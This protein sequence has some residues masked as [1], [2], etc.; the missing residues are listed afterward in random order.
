MNWQEILDDIDDEQAILFLGPELIRLDGQSL[1]AHVREQLHRQFPEDI[2][3]HYRRDGIF[4]FRD[5]NAKVKAQKQV[6]RLYRQLP[7][8]EA[9]LQRIAA[10][11][12]HLVIALTPDTFLR[13]AFEQCGLQPHFHYYRSDDTPDSL[14][15]PERGRPLIYNLFGEINHDESLVLD[16]DDVFQLMK[17]CLSTGLPTR[18][19]AQLQRASTFVFLGFD[20]EKWHTQMLLR[21]LSQRPGISKFAI[22]GE[23]PGDDTRDFLLHQ[24]KINFANG[25]E[26]GETFFDSLYRHCRETGKLRP[27]ANLYSDA[28][29]KIMRLAYA[30]KLATALDELRQA[31][32]EQDDLDEI[33]LLGARLHTI[34]EQ[35]K[36]GTLDSRDYWVEWNKIAYNVTR[37]AKKVAP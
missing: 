8:D 37:L 31:L 9:L 14:P 33:A 32:R 28:Q 1:G 5:D 34:E 19:N 27:L 35:Q 36:A 16:Y 7:P 4:L 12:F 21:F 26:S 13:D 6:K 11:P 25:D 24:F 17:D 29:T 20:F 23:R 22:E 2:L 15:K 18:I 30:G 3:H 10:V